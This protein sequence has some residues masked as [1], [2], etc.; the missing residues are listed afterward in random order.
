MKDCLGNEILVGD[1]IFCARK[2]E[3]SGECKVIGFTKRKLRYKD[4]HC[5]YVVFQQ[6]SY[7]KEWRD[8]WQTIDISAYQRSLQGEQA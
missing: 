6:R 1:I 8:G 2:N 4:E 3:L 7:E 5:D